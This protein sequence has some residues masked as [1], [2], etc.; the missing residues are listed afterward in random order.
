[1]AALPLLKRTL[2][3][4]APHPMYRLYRRWRVSRLTAAYEP[5]TVTHTYS[6]H[7]LTISLQDG[8]AEGWYDCDK[9]TPAEFT[10]MREHGLRPGATVF[11]LGAFQGIVALMLARE[12]GPT[13]RVIAVE[14]N[15]HNF[16]VAQD[17]RR[18]NDADNLT[19]VHAA[20]TSAPGT[21][22]FAAEFNGRIDERARLGNVEVDAITI[23][24]LAEE[25]GLPDV[26][27]MDIEGYEL[28]AMRGGAKVLAAAN[29]TWSIE[30]H[31]H[32]FVDGNPDDL[33]RA[34]EGRR[35]W[36]ADNA[37]SGSG[38]QYAPFEGGALP[39]GRFFVL[40]AP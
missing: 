6:G 27:Y 12:V 5:R 10:L 7:R 13:G 31:P 19:I 26:V 28:E 15:P 29:V 22:N 11:N 25:H 18:L 8:I 34:L 39:H 14:G 3:T 37:P 36:I 32:L 1:M 38:P 2:R 30:M 9:Q 16:A 35:I 23:D 33:L 21:V 17:N 4:L 24:Q 20:V 40:A